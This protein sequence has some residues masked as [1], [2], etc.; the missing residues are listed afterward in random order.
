MK[1]HRYLLILVASLIAAQIAVTLFAN[2]FFLMNMYLF[3]LLLYLVPLFLY[4][5]KVKGKSNKLIP[6]LPGI[7]LLYLTFAAVPVC[8]VLIDVTYV[9]LGGSFAMIAGV[10][11]IL[12]AWKTTRVLKAIAAAFLLLFVLWPIAVTYIPLR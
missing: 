10:S 5:G 7:Y 2:S 12:L 11:M 6:I 1:T 4:D 8:V 3:S 9:I